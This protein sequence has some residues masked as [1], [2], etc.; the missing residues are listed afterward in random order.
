[1]TFGNPYGGSGTGDA[2][3]GVKTGP[4]AAAAHSHRSWMRIVILGL[5]VVCVAS[6]KAQTPAQAQTPA[7]SAAPP[8]TSGSAPDSSSAAAPAAVEPA[9]NPANN[10][11]IQQSVEI[12]YRDS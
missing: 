3:R 2:R 9:P 7:P 11:T 5:A 12:G 1:M 8:Q 6:A 4:A 10:Y